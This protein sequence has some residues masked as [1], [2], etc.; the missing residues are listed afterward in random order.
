MSKPILYSSAVLVYDKAKNLVLGVSRKNNNT[1]FGFPGGK[2]DF[3]ETFWEAA[4]RELKEETGLN[5]TVMCFVHDMKHSNE[6]MHYHCCVFF[7][8]VTGQLFTTE[9]GIVSWLEP[10]VLAYGPFGDLSRKTFEIMNI[11][12]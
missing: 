3:G 8:E 1:L 6:R 5:A 2:V 11:K 9:K 4:I 10:K 7:A 12:Y